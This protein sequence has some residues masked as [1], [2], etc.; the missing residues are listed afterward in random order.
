MAREQYLLHAGEETIHQP[1]E[2]QKPQTPK[3]KWENFWFYHRIHI[4]IIAVVVFFAGI[5]LWQSLQTVTPDYTVGM[6]TSRV[7]P[8]S[9][10][11]ALQDAMQKYGKDL[12]GDGRVVVQINQYAISSSDSGVSSGLSEADP[13]MQEAMQVKLAAD[14]TTG[15]SMIFLTDDASFRSQESKNHL[16]AY[17]D[18]ST[19]PET[20]TDYG[21]MRV[22]LGKCAAFRELDSAGAA[23]SESGIDGLS[24]SLRVYAGSAIDG[25]ADASYKN[26]KELF[27]K[28]TRDS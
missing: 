2:N 25:K 16:F 3:K 13:Q 26:C 9:V 15:T 8:D 5:F 24:I 12:N 18:G 23:S 17:L 6:I 14:L 28:L 22:A 7:Y 1:G 27:A 20:E 10:T 19:P 4:L 21:K 11:E